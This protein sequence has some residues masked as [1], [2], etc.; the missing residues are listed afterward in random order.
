M[1][2]KFTHIL[3]CLLEGFLVRSRWILSPL[4][5]GLACT[6]ILLAIKFIQE[7]IH[8]IPHILSAT[9]TELILQILGLVDIVLIANL[10]LMIIF[11]G[12]EN[13]VSKID[14]LENHEDRPSWMGK[15]D[16]SALKLKVI[17]SVVAISSIELLRAFMGIQNMEKE[18]LAWLIGL[19]VTFVVSGLVFALTEKYGHDREIH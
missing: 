9:G 12:Y 8:I 2:N 13:F 14:L 17:G 5:V 7:F 19:H 1:M 3:E 11:S 16:Y 10:I 6:L 15:I 18:N 4:Y